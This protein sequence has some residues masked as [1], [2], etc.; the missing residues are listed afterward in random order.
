MLLASSHPTLEVCLK[1]FGSTYFAIA[2]GLALP[3]P[4]PYSNRRTATLRHLEAQSVQERTGHQL[5]RRTK[6]VRR[7]REWSSRG[8]VPGPSS[9]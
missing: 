6:L 4:V 8:K 9:P 5:L 3:V 7:I 1:D 2:L